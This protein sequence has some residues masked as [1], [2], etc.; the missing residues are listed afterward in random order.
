MDPSGF[1]MSPL[2][3]R[4]CRV[5]PF[6][7]DMQKTCRNIGWSASWSCSRSLRVTQC[8]SQGAPGRQHVAYVATFAPTATCKFPPK[9]K[10][11]AASRPPGDFCELCSAYF[12]L[13]WSAFC[14][15]FDAR[16]AKSKCTGASDSVSA[17]LRAI[18]KV[19]ATMV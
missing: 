5:P 18:T 16:V 17:A 19:E 4:P 1:A 13:A 2:W 3:S 8:D 15:C 14:L 6:K 11:R 10:V 7:R 9:N 12:S